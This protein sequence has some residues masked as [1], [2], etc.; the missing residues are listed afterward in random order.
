MKLKAKIIE[1]NNKIRMISLWD[2]F[3]M[4]ICFKLIRDLQF[5][6][7]EIAIYNAVLLQTHGMMKEYH[8]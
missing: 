1:N 5:A 3:K 4:K 6:K 8:S 7:S 2:I